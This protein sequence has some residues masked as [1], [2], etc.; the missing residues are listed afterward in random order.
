MSRIT[1]TAGRFLCFV[2][3]AAVCLHT[4]PA[5]AGT[6]TLTDADVACSNTDLL[7]TQFASFPGTLSGPYGQPTGGTE[8][9]LRDG[10][11]LTSSQLAADPPCVWAGNSSIWIYTLNT[12]VNTLGYDLSQVNLFHGYRFGGGSRCAGG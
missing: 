2:M 8:P 4:V 11:A 6:L 3:L 7:Q 5:F 12:T 1:R 10:V 9:L